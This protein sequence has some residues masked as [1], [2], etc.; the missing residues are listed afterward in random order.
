[1]A[2]ADCTR[3]RVILNYDERLRSEVKAENLGRVTAFDLTSNSEFL[4]EAI[5]FKWLKSAWEAAPARPRLI[6][7]N[8]FA[9]SR[10]ARIR[11]GLFNIDLDVLVGSGHGPLVR[12]RWHT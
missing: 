4:L 2:G 5:L 10:F 3:Q 11:L 12:E 6:E 1:M 9:V 7:D 8:L